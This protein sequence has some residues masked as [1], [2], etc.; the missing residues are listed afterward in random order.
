MNAE[1][2]TIGDELL[3]GQV[4]DTNSA[5]IATEL[6]KIGI[7]IHQITSV[8][9]NSEHIKNALNDA[10]SRASVIIITGGLGPTKDDITKQTLCEYF[11]SKLI[12]NEEA[13]ENVINIF[14]RYNAPVLDV[15]K[16]QAEVPDNCE[17][18]LNKNGTAPGML[19]RKDGKLFASMPG[20][21]FEMM[22]MMENQV[23]PAINQLFSLPSIIHQTLLTSG[24]GESFIA[25]KLEVVENELPPHLKIA[26][27]PKLGQV[28][29]RLS[30][31]GEDKA[32]LETE[33]KIYF[34]EIKEILKE[35][36]IYEGD[37]FVEHGVVDALK[38]KGKTLAVA[39][40]CTGGYI[41]HLLTSISGVS[42]VYRGGVVPYT[43]DLKTSLI[44]VSAD[45]ISTYGAVSEEVV[46]E[47][48]RGTLINFN[49]DFAIAV[50]GVAG[51]DGGTIEKPVGLVYIGVANANHVFVKSFRF[52]NKRVQN[53]ERSAVAALTMLYHEIMK[54]N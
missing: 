38:K 8:S 42:S 43:N 33:S 30:A 5:W 41:S 21:P 44:G 7:R 37:G 39:E 11:D 23:I 45:T 16:K 35:C 48:L 14:R 10:A 26:Y 2:V 51:P 53:I 22:S 6:N 49:S 36:M 19:F 32:V 27:L 25:S 4:V 46:S 47:M 29:I 20:V 24:V 15:N 31:Y 40:S 13:L 18:L 1:I 3:I 52:G 17:V 28:R 50:S 54:E 12:I 9:D 34:Q